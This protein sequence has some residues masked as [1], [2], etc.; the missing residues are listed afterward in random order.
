MTMPVTPD[1]GF[2]APV[3][4]AN[5]LLAPGPCTMATAVHGDLGVLTFRTPT[6]TLTLQ[7]PKA[8][9]LA[10]ARLIRE[11]GDSMAGGSGLLVARPSG[12][13]LRP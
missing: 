2:P 3:D 1:A 11:L 13:L 5:A 6:T 8:D 9:I 12:V 7:L 4:E 10:W